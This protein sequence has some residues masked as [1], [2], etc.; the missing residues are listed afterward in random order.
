ML[1]FERSECKG[2]SIFTNL[3]INPKE[4]SRINIRFDLNTDL[5]QIIGHIHIILLYF[6]AKSYFIIILLALHYSYIDCRFASFY[7][8]IQPVLSFSSGRF[9]SQFGPF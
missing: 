8:S 4:N 1:F 2:T 6:V 3:Q 9:A 7:L 5:D